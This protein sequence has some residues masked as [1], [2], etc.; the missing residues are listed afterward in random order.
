MRLRARPSSSSASSPAATS[1]ASSALSVVRSSVTSTAPAATESPDSNLIA[2]TMPEAS[3][4]TSVPICASIVPTAVRVMSHLSLNAVA[5]ETVT[6]GTGMLSKYWFIIR[7]PNHLKPKTP[8]NTSAV[9]ASMLSIRK[10][11]TTPF[12]TPSLTLRRLD[13]DRRARP[14]PRTARC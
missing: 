6:A 3:V 7:L 10:F 4:V 11:I 8:P 2:S 14:P 12:L 9:A 5:V 1:A 13:Y